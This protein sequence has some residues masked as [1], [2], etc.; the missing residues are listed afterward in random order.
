[1]A[2]VE[3]ETLPYDEVTSEELAASAAEQIEEVE[4]QPEQFLLKGSCPRCGFRTVMLIPRRVFLRG[5]AQSSDP[6]L[7]RRVQEPMACECPRA[8]P[9]RPPGGVGC[10]AYWVLELQLNS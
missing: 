6:T 5:N 3:C 2:G 9:N 4:E 7:G 8:H 1:M 10:G